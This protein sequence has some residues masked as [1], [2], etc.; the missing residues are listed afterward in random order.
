MKLCKKCFREF[1]ENEILDYSPAR[2]LGEIFMSAVCDVDVEDLCP[3]C[4]EEFGVKS[5]I[6]FNR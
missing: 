1:H 6:G 2:D 4:R 5:L 3:E